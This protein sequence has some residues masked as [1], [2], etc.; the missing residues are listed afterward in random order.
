VG[1]RRELA[2][3]ATMLGR[4]RA[5]GRAGRPGRAVLLRGRRR[6]GKSRLVE[7]FVEQAKVPALFF[8]AS[9]QPTVEAELRL[10]VQAAAASDLPGAALFA[11]QSPSTWDAALSLLAAALPTDRASIVVLD[12]MPYLLATDAGFEGTLQKMFDRELSRRPVLLIGIGSDLAMMEALNEYGRPFHQRA[13]EMVLPPLNPADVVEM[14]RLTAAAAFDAYLVSGGL[15]LVLDEW[16]AGVGALDY[17]A[18]AVRDPTSALLVSG[19][20]ALAAEFPPESHGRAVLGAIGAGERSFTAIGTASGLPTASLHRALQTLV[21]KRVVEAITPLST[22]PSRETRYIVA[23][24]HLRFWL[25]LLGPYLPEIERGRGDL[26]LARIHTQWTSWRGRAI[27]PVVREALRRLPRHLPP[28]TAVVGGYW[29]RT[30]DP[31]IDLVGADKSPSANR[32]TMVGSIKWQ[33]RRGF[34]A[35]DLARL[36][37]HRTRLPGADADTPL[38]AVTRTAAR[39]D[40]GVKLLGPEDLLAAYEEQP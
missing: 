37:V 4:V 32:I 30:N 23:D 17:L 33:E 1:R 15:P 7:R 38:L 27:E 25:A 13:T 14:L 9:A 22:Q 21:A 11:D 35:H 20:R 34:D 16:P 2:L 24:P 26:V 10:F 19:E 29:T 18:D 12:E 8:T 28:G 6:V 39:S 40:L 31:E 3:L 36:A 5:G